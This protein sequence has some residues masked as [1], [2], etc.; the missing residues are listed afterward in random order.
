MRG[1]QVS[2]VLGVAK[3]IGKRLGG[4]ACKRKN[5]RNNRGFI[6]RMALVR[7]QQNLDGESTRG[8]TQ[9]TKNYG[10]CGVDYP[11]KD[12]DPGAQPGKRAQDSGEQPQVLVM[13]GEQG[14]NKQCTKSAR[15]AGNEGADLFNGKTTLGGIGSKIKKGTWGAKP[16]GQKLL[17]VGSAVTMTV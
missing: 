13:G 5:E 10:R 3:G 16:R 8:R 12:I 17:Q 2:G 9:K 1:T 6:I 14:R 11:R 4:N 15:G 7:R